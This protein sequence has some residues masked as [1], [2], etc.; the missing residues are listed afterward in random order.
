IEVKLNLGYL[1][2]SNG[3]YEESP[4]LFRV[5]YF[6]YMVDLNANGEIIGGR[7]YPDSSV[8]DM[9]WLPLQPKQARQ[10]GNEAGNPYLSTQA[11]LALWRDSVPEDVRQRWVVIDPTSED[12]QLVMSNS[13]NLIPL[14][15][16][17]HQQE[18]AITQADPPES[19]DDASPV[20]VSEELTEGGENSAAVESEQ[21]L[22]SDTTP[23][24]TGDAVSAA[25]D[26]APVIVA[27]K[28]AIAPRAESR[29]ITDLDSSVFDDLFPDVDD[30]PPA[31]EEE[32]W[33]D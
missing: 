5:K 20:V 13:D 4:K 3:E 11:I 10:Q 29:V 26:A 7:F 8:I 27:E 24:E 28:P 32:L 33:D 16:S 15:Y 1:R 25:E 18:E 17:I 6:H 2:D 31:L 21:P 22:T 9:L 19:M 23:A 12:N 30:A 14:G